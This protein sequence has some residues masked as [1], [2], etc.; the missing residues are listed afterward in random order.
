[1]CGNDT[2]RCN[3]L[4]GLKEN[5][6]LLFENSEDIENLVNDKSF[7]LLEGTNETSKINIEGKN[8]TNRR[9]EAYKEILIAEI[10]KSITELIITDRQGNRNREYLRKRSL[11][12]SE[13]LTYLLEISS[14]KGEFS[15]EGCK[16]I[17]EKISILLTEILLIC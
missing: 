5:F 3:Y 15:E 2:R 10:S 12:I 13:I 11:I 1:M 16:K 9:A 8:E 7:S 4:Q 14:S 6:N 17:S